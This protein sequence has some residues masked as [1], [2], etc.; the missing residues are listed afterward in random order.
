MDDSSIRDNIGPDLN[1]ASLSLGS[2]ADIT[3]SALHVF[4]VAAARGLSASHS[5]PVC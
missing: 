2:R 1:I 3:F 4:T 5:Q